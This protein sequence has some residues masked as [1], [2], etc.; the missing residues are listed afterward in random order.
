MW[1]IGAVSGILILNKYTEYVC[2]MTNFWD[3]VS[4]SCFLNDATEINISLLIFEIGPQLNLWG[5]LSPSLI[6]D[7]LLVKDE[8][9]ALVLDGGL[10][11]ALELGSF[12][13]QGQE[14][15]AEKTM[16]RLSKA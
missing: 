14:L 12:V 7:S 3:Y 5:K 1:H 8:V 10:S 4:G 6:R 15:G 11:P 9:D 16:L 13:Q 2:L